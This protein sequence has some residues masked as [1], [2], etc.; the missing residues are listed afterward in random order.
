MHS[1]DPEG[2]GR[3][4]DARRHTATLPQTVPPHVMSSFGQAA[5]MR[6]E[7]ESLQSLMTPLQLSSAEAV[8]EDSH[9]HFSYQT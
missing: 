9:L 7:G 4:A 6:S 1:P 5:R 3:F 8:V 2:A